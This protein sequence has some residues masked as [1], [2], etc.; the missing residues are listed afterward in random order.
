MAT[1]NG[2]AGNNT[3]N[4][5]PAED[6]IS[7]YGGDDRLSGAGG[8]DSLF[9]GDGNDT[10]DGGDGSNMLDGGA[11]A[12]Q[13]NGGA[14]SGDNTIYGGSGSD[15]ITSSFGRDLIYGGDDDDRIYA[16][17]GNDRV[18]GGA[19]NDFIDGGLGSDTLEGGEGF[20]TF[21]AGN[22]D[23]ITDFN[24]GAGQNIN[25]GN[26]GNNDYVDLSSFYN[27]TNLARYNSWAAANGH[28]TYTTPLA[29][30]RADQDGDGVLN[31]LSRAGIQSFNFN[32]QN[33]G[34]AV[35]GQN[36]TFDNTNVVCFASDVM[37]ATEDGQIAAGDL[38]VG[39]MVATLDNGVQALRW[40]GKRTICAAEMEAA[41]QI[42]PI[43][44]KRGALGANVPEA[45]LIVSPQHRIL[46]RSRIAYRMFGTV[47]VLVAAKQL[48]QLDGIDIATDLTEVTYVHFM[49][50][51]HQIVLAN[52]AEAE[53]LYTGDEALKSVGPE[54]VAEIFALFPEL[55]EGAKSEPARLLTSGR[56]ARKLAVRHLQNRQPLV[57]Q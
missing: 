24:T 10:L 20:D 53:S 43:R 21:V 22:G 14:N 41:P 42:R 8:N 23:T 7:G 19:G 16:G 13:L 5:T 45:D 37:I 44:I 33:G 26:Q 25:D 2:T 56:M 36:L 11:G 50:D 9:G 51:A 30:L 39:D 32:V 34:S 52:G 54:A 35:A 4:G 29:W 17:G 48:L 46:V 27:G 3:L 1:I 38:K 6:V 57:K 55:A 28:P 31:D 40:I 15:T 12:D 49:F 18:F 47:E